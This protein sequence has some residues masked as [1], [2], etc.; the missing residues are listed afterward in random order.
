ML[1]L[2]MACTDNVKDTA[3]HQILESESTSGCRSGQPP[4]EQPELLLFS[5]PYTEDAGQSPLWR[6]AIIENTLT[7]MTETLDLGRAISGSP[8]FSTDASWGVVVREDGLISTIAVDSNAAVT[9]IEVGRDLGIYVAAAAIHRGGEELWLLDPN[10]PENGGGLYRSQIDC[11]DGRLSAPELLFSTKNAA[12]M[13]DTVDGLWIAAREADGAPGQA[14]LL[15]ISGLRTAQIFGDDEAILS[16]IA[17]TNSGRIVV[18]DVNEFSGLPTRIGWLN[19]D[20]STGTL[21]VGDPLR[22]LASPLD[23]SMLILSGYDNAVYVFDGAELSEPSYQGAAPQ[24]PTA[25]VGFSDGRVY[26]AENQGIR[27]MRFTESGVVDDGLLL[28]M[29]GLSGI[30]GALGG[31]HSR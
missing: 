1:L 26:I 29:D 21:N 9:P 5:T 6:S 23:D 13:I 14:H 12:A 2:L 18:A 19:S 28:E 10:W 20:G 11:D 24:L 22:L 8:Q 30:T 31:T 3:D 17:R 7:L 4:T 27:G 16:D 25:A 15:G